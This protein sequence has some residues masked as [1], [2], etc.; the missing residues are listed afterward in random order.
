V[1]KSQVPYSLYPNQ[2]P[3]NKQELPITKWK[4]AEA[5]LFVILVGY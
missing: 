4:Q 3:L 1:T 2:Y 5:V